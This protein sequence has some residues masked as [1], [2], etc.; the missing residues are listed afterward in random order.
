VTTRRNTF[1]DDILSEIGIATS[2]FA[3]DLPA[4][5]GTLTATVEA[6][7]PSPNRPI[8]SGKTKRI[9]VDVSEDVWIAIKIVAARQGTT[10]ACLVRRHLEVLVSPQPR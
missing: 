4:E 10:V 3:G 2:D 5:S 1:D 9:G 7:A 8:V 6:R